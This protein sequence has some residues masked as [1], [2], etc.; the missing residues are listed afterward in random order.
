MKCRSR[1]LAVYNSAFQAS[2]SN[3]DLER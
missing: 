3:Y 1:I 2:L